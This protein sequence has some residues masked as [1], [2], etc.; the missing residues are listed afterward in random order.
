[1]ARFSHPNAVI[2]HD[3]DISG[4]VAFIDMDYVPGQSLNALLGRGQPMPLDWT[5]RVLRQLGEVVGLLREHRAVPQRGDGVLVAVAVQDAA[6]IR[7]QGQH[8][9]HQAAHDAAEQGAEAGRL[10]RP[11]GDLPGRLG[12]ERDALLEQP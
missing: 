8:R 10:L 12:V 3:T 9:V 2:V 5:A 1:M 11:A 4:D 7:A 6:G